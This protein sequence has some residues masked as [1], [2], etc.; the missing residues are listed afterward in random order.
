MTTRFSQRQVLFLISAL[1]VMA[2]LVA[3]EPIRHN[4]FINYDDDKYITKNSDVQRGL[5]RDSVTWAFTH[6]HQYMWHPLTTLSH[7]LDCELFGLNPLGHHLVSLA[8]HI[9]NALLL[10]WILVSLTGSTWAS[11]FVAAVFALHPLQVESVAWAAER[12]TVMSGL[13]WFLTIAVYIWYTKKP[14]IGRYI[15]VFAIYGLCIMTKPVV[16]TLPLVLLLLDYWPLERIGRRKI[17]DPSSLRFAEAG[18]GQQKVSPGWLIVEKIPLLV[19][20]A[21]LSILTLIAQHSGGAVVP[22]EAKPLDQ[23]IAH[24]F[25]SYIT[26]IGKMIAP[27]RLAVFYP[28]KYATFSNASVII[29]M[30]LFILITVLCIYIG[31]R[32]KYVAVGW[33]WFV[34]TLVP[35]TGLVQAGSQ[36][37][38]DRYMYISMLGLLIIIVW[39]VK[40]I[41]SKRPH[42]R[43]VAV[44]LTVVTLSSAIILTR[45][46]VR[47]WENSL[48]LFEHTL[49]VTENNL[50]GENN[51]ASALFDAGRFDE[52]LVHLNN[53]IRI[54]STNFET[55]IN[56]GKVLVKQKKFN[57]AIA[58]FNELL[59]QKQ[60]TAEVHYNWALA[61]SMQKKYDDAIK[62][63]ARALDMD[64]HYP[65]ARNLMGVALM[66]IGRINEAIECFSELLR[67]KQDTAEVHYNWALA[68]SM[69]KKY[70]DAIEQLAV[71]LKLE[72]NYAGAQE[73]MGKSLLTAGRPKDA[74]EHLNEALRTSKEPVK[75]YENLGKA[76]A[77]LGQYRPAIQNWTKAVELKP[78]NVPVLNDLAWLLATTGD[79]SAED[80]NKAVKYAQHVCDFTGYKK[81]EFLDTLAVAYAAAGRFE[82]AVNTANQA[83]DI[84]RAGNQE[85]L[86]NEIQ[87]RMKLYQAG[88]RYQQ[89]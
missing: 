10:F 4:G 14:G 65:N 19:L 84:A 75:V 57:E 70:D 7:M 59:R 42:W 3:Y 81:P 16:V 9:V 89:K 80:A 69:Q 46:Q 33:L 18:R 64:P 88:Q 31:R 77:Q 76:Y 30:L 87:S 43:V 54:D 82:D 1:L 73:I 67:Q 66:A 32:K 50:I 44:V 60:D 13:F 45:I 55:R 62:H 27:S 12:K 63:F 58:C 86:A 49:K 56:I 21:I 34:V 29:C 36:A 38:A 23:R 47:Y 35:M 28:Y 72:P 41:V 74:I 39:A 2:T 20:S 85:D 17:E 22:L 51:Y 79:V 40:E 48:T 5:T 83:I 61:L 26:Y 24:L 11:A 37:M 25:V 15:L 71:V 6:P 68:L 78:D 53:S 52:V 8:L